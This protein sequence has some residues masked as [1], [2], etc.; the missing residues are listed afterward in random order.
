MTG[1]TLTFGGSSYPLV[2]PSSRD[3]RLHV[4][5]VILTVHLLGQL[6]LG[7]QLSVP[8]LLSAMLT[9][10]VIEVARALNTLISA[11]ALPR[12]TRTIR[13]FW[14]AE[15][16]GDIM[17]M[18]KHPEWRD[19]ALSF[20]SVDMIGFNQEKVKAVPR[21]TRL[22]DFS[23]AISSS[24]AALTSAGVPSKVTFSP[25]LNADSSGTIGRSSR[26]SIRARASARSRPSSS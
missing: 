6:G 2:L 5:A 4:A 11:G 12:P 18:S 22:L 14:S 8:Q 1:R 17:M 3:P 25:P 26:S 7:F 21:L 10:A 13:F 20:F 23:F 19:R 16:F 24:S 15:H 9:C